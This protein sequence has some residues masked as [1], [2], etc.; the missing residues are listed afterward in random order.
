[1]ARQTFWIDNVVENTLATGTTIALSLFTG[2]PPINVRGSTII[3]IIFDLNLYS[4]TVAGAHGVQIQ[5]VAFG[6]A[7]QEAFNAGVLPD[8]DSDERP[9][10]GWMYRTRCVAF[11]NGVGT[12]PITK[13][14]GDLR[15]G[16]KISD[17][18][19]FM[20]LANRAS[21]GTT[22]AIITSGI[23]RLLLLLP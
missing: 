11:Q 9:V 4:S 8:P 14:A 1:M 12:N 3:R 19:A 21:M 13:C 16:R 6:M 7:S 20:V 23:I 2:T 10:G 17:G 15:S 22:F 5:D 18:E